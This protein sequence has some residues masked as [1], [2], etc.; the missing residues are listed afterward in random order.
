MKFLIIIIKK[1]V[2][3]VILMKSTSYMSIKYMNM[4]SLLRVDY[5]STCKFPMVVD[6]ATAKIV[7]DYPK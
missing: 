2:I 5:V 4:L 1:L 7:K 3:L 6:F